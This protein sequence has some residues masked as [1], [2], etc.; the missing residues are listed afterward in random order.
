M[1][2]NQIT[3]RTKAM[4]PTVLLTLLSIV[5]AL[6]LELMWS[7]VLVEQYLYSWSLEA[8]IAWAQIFANFLGILLIWLI[9]S[10]VVL[11][12]SWVPS[13]TDASFP[14]IVGILEFFQIANLGPGNYGLWFVALGTIFGSMSWI[15][16]STMR[17][18]Q[19]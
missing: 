7:H 11:R 13:T 10:D 5:Q 4:F 8:V 3:R 19:L 17:P 6:A 15:S 2:D 16:Q 18:H 12:L 14:F 1:P 9:Y